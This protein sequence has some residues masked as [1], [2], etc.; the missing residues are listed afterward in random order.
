M[1]EMRRHRVDMTVYVDLRDDQARMLAS[2]DE[3]VALAGLTHLESAF[4]TLLGAVQVSIIDLEAEEL[5]D[6]K[7]G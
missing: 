6:D 3:R 7:E 5:P 1:G 4:K 2:N